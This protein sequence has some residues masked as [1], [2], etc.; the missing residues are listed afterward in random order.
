M[1]APAI[2]NGVAF[3]RSCT[4]QTDGTGAG[5]VIS[6]AQLV[7][8]TA[9]GDLATFIATPRATAAAAETAFRNL[10]GLISYRV[11]AGTAVTYVGWT[12]DGATLPTITIS[13]GGADTVIEWKIELA[14]T[15]NA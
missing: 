8:A 3:A 13:A 7:A 4:F 1:A 15:V 9:K 10:G 14:H 2:V 12:V 11:T 6:N 5:D